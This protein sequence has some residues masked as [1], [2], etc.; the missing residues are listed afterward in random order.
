[1]I[2]PD[3]LQLAPE[4]C[5]FHLV[6][7]RESRHTL[8]QE[9]INE[10]LV[11]LGREGG[12]VVRL[13]GG[14]PFVFGRGGEEAE[15]LEKHGVPWRAIPGV[16]SA[17]GGA[18]GAGIPITQ[19][20]NSSSVL[21]ATGHRRH[22]AEDGAAYWRE[23]AS[24]TGTSALYMGTSN[25]VSVADKLV[26]C[27]K[28][29]QTPVSVVKWGGWNRIERTDGTLEEIAAAARSG[30]LPAPS[31]VF[32]GGAAGIKLSPEKGTL[33]GLQVVL[34]RPY[35]ECWNTGRA[36]E[37]MSADS[38]G[39]P[40]LSLEPI[41][42]DDSEVRALESADWLVISSPRGAVRLREIVGD[43]RRI[44]GKVIS[45][46]TSTSAS[47]R[48]NGIIPDLEADG[49]SRSLAR[50]LEDTVSRGDS[51]VFARNERGSD[52]A[53][54]AATRKGAAVRI[55]PTY[56]M[57]PREVPGAEV[58]REHW[59]AC[60]VDAV[61]FGSSAMAEAYF[62][63]FG[64]PPGSSALIAWGDECGASVRK[65]FARDCLVMKTPD[66]TGLIS[67]LEASMPGKRCPEFENI[68]Q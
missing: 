59:D 48:K 5:R 61:V 29:P 7:K 31:I 12:V 47:L 11:R 68:R 45:I 23:I 66:M 64:N 32:I 25:F 14:D 41:S 16:T 34:C 53:A 28:S 38:Y 1:L 8:R 18:L 20:E 46:G 27:G 26:S 43:L 9:E 50:M 17:I 35:P 39:L 56:R 55:V 63:A 37:R 60:G 36:L 40:L 22:G 15:F 30:G 10:L 62:D 51:V 67:A 3:L 58:M 13:K 57:T 52:I 49:H 21:L 42:P 19:R 65:I 2:H 44:R 54:A 24:S 6:G 33:S 4:Y